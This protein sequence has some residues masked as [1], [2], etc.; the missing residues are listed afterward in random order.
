MSGELKPLA[1]LAALD[2]GE[3]GRSPEGTAMLAALSREH[4]AQGGPARERPV[5]RPATLDH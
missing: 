3:S 2:A 1:Q 5:A 4:I